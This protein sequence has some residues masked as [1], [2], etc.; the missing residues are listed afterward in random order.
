MQ[1]TAADSRASG[2]LIFFSFLFSY[3]FVFRK[4]REQ[5][6]TDERKCAGWPPG[7][8]RRKEFLDSHIF[9]LH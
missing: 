9:P 2:P 6:R 1:P 7:G 8:R 4:K 3:A 5:Q